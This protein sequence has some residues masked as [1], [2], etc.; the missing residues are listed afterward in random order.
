MCQ[1]PA[2]NTKYKTNYLANEP[3]RLLWNGFRQNLNTMKPLFPI[4]TDISR[5]TGVSME[6]VLNTNLP[7]SHED[8]VRVIPWSIE[9]WEDVMI[10]SDIAVVIKPPDNFWQRRKPP[11][12]VI[13]FMAA[14]L[15]TIC[16]PTV[17]DETII[18]HGETA[19][20]AY[21]KEDWRR[22][23]MELATSEE[24][25]RQMG[26]AAR[27]SVLSQFSIAH[28][29]EEHEN[30]FRNVLQSGKKVN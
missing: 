24:R 25:R 10:A 17:A 21:S 4:V 5:E 20:A 8:G 11:A 26:E 2:I 19:Y 23:L 15:P 28:I 29:A 6:V 3:L 16:T 30:I 12:K 14:G 7:E 1:R 13:T 18:H 27:E 9:S 22:F